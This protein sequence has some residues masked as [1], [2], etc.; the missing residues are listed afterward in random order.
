MKYVLLAAL[1]LA[2]VAFAQDFE[3]NTGG[4][5]EFVADMQGSSTGWGEWFAVSLLNDTGH[6]IM[7]TEFGF[8][9]CGDPTDTLGWIVYL[10]VGGIN[11]PAGDPGTCDYNGPFTPVEGPG[12]DP[13]VY[14]YV[15]VSAENIVI[16][17][18][19]YWCFGYDVTDLGGQ[20]AYNG[21]ET[22]SWYDAGSG[23]F[24]DMDSGYSRTAVLQVKGDYSGALQS[25]TWGSIKS[26]F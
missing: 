4:S 6:D 22:W 8:P 1:L 10:D 24:W 19:N 23:F 16:P 20:T 15:D 7:L 18:G 25:A 2:S 13:S 26:T 14:T 3:Y 5:M 9:C 17:S 12:G 11:P 21:V